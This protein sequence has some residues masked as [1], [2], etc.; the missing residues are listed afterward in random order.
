[1]AVDRCVAADRL[2][3]D[4]I[5]ALGSSAQARLRS[6]LDRPGYRNTA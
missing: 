6:D 1:M 2:I 3:P 5:A 4:G